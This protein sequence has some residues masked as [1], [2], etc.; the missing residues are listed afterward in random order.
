MLEVTDQRPPQWPTD[1]GRQWEDPPCPAPAGGWPHVREN[2]NLE[3]PEEL[4]NDPAVAMLLMVRPSATQV[5]LTVVTSDPEGTR[6]RW[7]PVFPGRLCVVAA[8]WPRGK[9]ETLSNQA[10]S[11]MPQFQAY[12][13]GPGTGAGCQPVVT[14]HVV[15]VVPALVAWAA[16]LP[17]GLLDVHAWLRPLTAVQGTTPRR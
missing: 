4:V 17:A 16:D 2:E 3:L 14:L 13:T 12:Q 5:V 1:I 15:R 9:V 7:S 8:R 6:A 10:Q 11:R